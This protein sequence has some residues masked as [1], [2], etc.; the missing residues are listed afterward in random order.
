LHGYPFGFKF[1]RRLPPSSAHSVFQN[2]EV[3]PKISPSAPQLQIT[4]EQCQTLFG[5]SANQSSSC[6]RQPRSLTTNQDHLFSK[7]IG[8]PFALNVKH[9]VF[10]FTFIP[11][12]RKLENTWI[13]DTGATD[14]MISCISLFTT[15]P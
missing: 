15:M 12:S 2:I 10:H 4:L 3:L 1:T 7:M 5:I 14:H 11:F 8:N 13:V 6:F 9:F